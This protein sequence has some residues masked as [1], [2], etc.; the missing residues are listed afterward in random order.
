MV[1]VAASGTEIPGMTVRQWGGKNKD[2]VLAFLP[3]PALEVTDKRLG[4]GG[5]PKEGPAVC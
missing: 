4:N 3:S 5:G 1:G 2:R